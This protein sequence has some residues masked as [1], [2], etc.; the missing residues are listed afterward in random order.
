MNAVY[1]LEVFFAEPAL[2]VE[3][4]TAVFLSVFLSEVFTAVVIAFDDAFAFVPFS[5]EAFFLGLPPFLPF[6]LA[7]AAFFSDFTFPRIFP[8]FVK[9]SGISFVCHSFMIFF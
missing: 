6:S 8:A 5:T 4:F 1:F 2:L 7:A 9:G 3:V